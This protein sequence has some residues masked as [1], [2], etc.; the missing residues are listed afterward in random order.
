MTPERPQEPKIRDESGFCSSQLL[1]FRVLG[2]KKV[3]RKYYFIL[4]F[5]IQASFLILV[6][7]L[8]NSLPRMPFSTGSGDTTA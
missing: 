8:F 1:A 5:L 4:E 6:S 2:H 3:P 7:S